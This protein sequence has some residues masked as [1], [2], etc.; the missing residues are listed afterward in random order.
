MTQKTKARKAKAPDTFDIL[1]ILDRSGSMQEARTDHE[2]GLR[3][4][5]AQQ[6]A[7]PGAALFTLTQFD[8]EARCEVVYDRVPLTAVGEISLM[9]RGGTPLL[10][11]IGLAVSHLETA[12]RTAPSKSTVCVV[13][14]DGQENASREWTRA[15]V[16]ER[17]A[18]LE[19]SGW[20][21]VFL[22]ANIDA[23]AE[24][25]ALGMTRSRSSN[26]SNAIPSS[27]NNAYT[28]TSTKLAQ[29]RASGVSGQSV[30]A[31]MNFSAEEQE[32][33]ATGAP[34]TTTTEKR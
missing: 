27:V 1:V 11:A 2:G 24:G 4:F 17:I 20:T 19:K 22:G 7:T 12:Q 14:T 26:Y 13:I 6:R 5:V 8:T 10:D 32:A 9:P 18:A 16:A 15:R 23:F 33:I 34:V 21:F 28:L 29:V 25:G 31:C 30:G 3:A